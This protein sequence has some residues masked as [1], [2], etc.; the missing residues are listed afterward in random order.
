MSREWAA[1]RNYSCRYAIGD[2][3]RQHCAVDR[4]ESAGA[5]LYLHTAVSLETL[6]PE[7]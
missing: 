7:L 6:E 4:A 5:L 2:T 1:R 3:F